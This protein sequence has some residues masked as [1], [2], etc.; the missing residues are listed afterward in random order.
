MIRANTLKKAII[1]ASLLFGHLHGYSQDFTF[2]Q[3][4]EQPLLRNPAL[5]GVF[6][7]DIRVA[8]AHRSQWGSVTVPFRTTSLS[9]EHKIPVGSKNDIV[10]IASQ[11]SIDQAGD[12][13]LR[14]TQILPAINY[15]KSLSNDNDTYL[16]LAFMGGPV[17]SQFDASKLKLGDQ[18]VNGGFDPSNPTSQPITA[19]GYSYFDLTTG[20]CF[21]TAFQHKTRVY[22]AVGVAHVTNPKIKSVTGSIENFL[23]PR[24]S[25]NVGI[26]APAGE[27]GRFM[28]FVDYFSQNRNN[29]LLGGLMYGITMREYD[30]NEPDLF[31]VGTFLRW[32][33][34]V[35]PTVK[36][37]FEHFSIGVSYDVNISKLR[38]ASNWRGGLEL[39][40]TY[41]DFLKIRSSTLDKTRCVRF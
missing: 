9:V 37:E 32:N 24:L 33:D 34:A 15:H 26:N 31:Y 27:R 41:R 22:V 14:R 6:T 13:R 30:N 25:V 2:S 19:T 36:M 39:T 20:L 29:Q 1:A 40:A 12:L 18:Y 35:I 38:V 28:A 10:T 3:F 11:M 16:S 23:S 4:Y 21:S 8:A 17:S 7:G 5:A